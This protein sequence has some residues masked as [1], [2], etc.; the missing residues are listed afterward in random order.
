MV[1]RRGAVWREVRRFVI[2]AVL[3]IVALC[4]IPRARVNTAPCAERSVRIYVLNHGYHAGLIVPVRAQGV[5]WSNDVAFADG[6]AIELGWGDSTFFTS[7]GFPVDDA[8]KALFFLSRSS[9]MHVRAIDDTSVIAGAKA[10]DLC[11]DQ[12]AALAAF[13]RGSFRRTPDGR[14]IRLMTG[15]DGARSAFYAATGSYSILND[16]NAWL[17]RA[18]HEAGQSTALWAPLP[19]VILWH[20]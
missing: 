9:V 12:Y 14:T 13:V 4:V 18:L 7:N 19:Q 20:L 16:C 6:Q 1:Q 2:G 5:D 8:F 17:S 10:L 11:P 15:L 3:A